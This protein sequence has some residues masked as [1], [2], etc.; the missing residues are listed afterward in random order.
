MNSLYIRLFNLLHFDYRLS[1]EVSVSF[2][3][4]FYPE[5]QHV[6]TIRRDPFERRPT[7]SLRLHLGRVHLTHLSS[8]IGAE[9]T[10]TRQADSHSVNLLLTANAHPLYNRQSSNGARDSSPL[11]G[12]PIHGALRVRSAIGRRPRHV[13][14]LRRR[15]DSYCGGNWR[16]RDRDVIIGCAV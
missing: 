5:I 6:R 1:S 13:V 4:K 15:V 16:Q 10:R 7:P 2:T 8:F 3:V 9:W 12:R 14:T 11:S